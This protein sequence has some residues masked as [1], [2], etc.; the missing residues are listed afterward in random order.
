MKWLNG[1]QWIINNV[2]LIQKRENKEVETEYE[3]TGRRGNEESEGCALK[4]HW[5]AH[6]DY[7]W[8]M[9]GYC[10]LLENFGKLWLSTG[11]RTET[12]KL[13]GSGW[14]PIV[15]W[16]YH[17]GVSLVHRIHIA[18]NSNL[19]VNYVAEIGYFCWF[20]TEE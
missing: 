10:S 15:C 1:A 6:S 17:S 3:G 4:E 5:E 12:L 9:F 18:G 19:T 16:R 20:S 7:A 13:G 8:F 14:N 11:L 2:I